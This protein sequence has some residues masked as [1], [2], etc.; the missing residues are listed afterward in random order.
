MGAD[1]FAEFHRGF[2]GEHDREGLIVDRAR[3]RANRRERP[4]PL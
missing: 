1:G 3:R 4:E 2:P